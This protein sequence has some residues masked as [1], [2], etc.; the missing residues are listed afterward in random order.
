MSGYQVTPGKLHDAG[1]S[2]IR[3]GNDIAAQA[4][5]VDDASDV[6][7]A[8]A[9]LGVGDTLRAVDPLWRQ[10]LRAVGADV[11]AT[12]EKLNATAGNYTNNELVNSQA[13]AAILS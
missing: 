2:A 7:T 3:I 9:G 8:P 4:D 10:H 11:R 6:P 1:Q 12:G 5:R 13:F